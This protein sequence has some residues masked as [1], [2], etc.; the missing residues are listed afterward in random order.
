MYVALSFGFGFTLG[1]LSMVRPV[2]KLQIE[3]EEDMVW[4]RD[5]LEWL[6]EQLEWLKNERDKLFELTSS[7][8]EIRQLTI[9]ELEE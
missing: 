3:V 4:L 9:D 7:I 8:D 5:Q 6:G 2:R 1:G